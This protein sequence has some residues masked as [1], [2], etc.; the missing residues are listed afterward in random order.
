MDI[1]RLLNAAAGLQRRGAAPLRPE[2]TRLAIVLLYTTGLRR[3]ELLNLTVRDY[4][5]KEST[6]H[7]RE[8]KFFKSRILPLN[9]EIAEEIDRYLQAR[10]KRGLSTSLDTKMIRNIRQGGQSYKGPALRSSIRLLLKECHIATAGG[11]LPRIHDFRHSFAVNAL[12]RWYRTGADVG[13]ML[14]LLATYMGHGT[15]ASTHYFCSSSNRSERQRATDLPSITGR[16]SPLH[17]KGKGGANENAVTEPAGRDHTRLFHGSSS[18]SPGRQS[19]HHSQLQR[20]LGSVIAV[21][22]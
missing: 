7:V 14:P 4:D 5:S 22:C 20:Q 17:R 19:A 2:V 10:A 13:A 12:L 8:T 3:G 18:R 1:A 21:R 9:A 16:W 6:L 15:A 11:K